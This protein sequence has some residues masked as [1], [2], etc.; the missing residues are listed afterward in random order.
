MA[1]RKENGVAAYV[2]VSS[3]QQNEAMQ[4]DAIDTWAKAHGMD[5]TI[6]LDKQSG[7]TMDRPAWNRLD[8]A[9]QA[10]K[11]KV[12]LVWRLD[13]LGRTMSGLARLFDDLRERGVKLISLR[14]NF[15]LLT[16]MG[17]MVAGVMASMAEYE[18][19][20]RGERVRGGQEAARKRGKTWGGSVRGWTKLT[21]EQVATIR[22][23]HAD[24]TSKRAIGRMLGISWPTVQKVLNEGP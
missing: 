16:P 19:E 6:Y 20:L 3:K 22:K 9:I 8:A 17:R 1:K 18:S 10:G 24:G 23:L 13:R 11:V 14:E 21:D 15:D 4:R 5:P 7:R 2:R 12:L